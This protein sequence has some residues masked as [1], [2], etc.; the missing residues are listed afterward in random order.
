MIEAV[1]PARARTAPPDHLVLRGVLI[2]AVMLDHNDIVRNVHTVNAWFLPMTWHVAGFLLL[3]FLTPPRSLS[4]PMVRDHAVRYLVPFVC[5][6]LAYAAAYQSIILRHPPD[7][8]TLARVAR[9]LLLADPTSLQHATGFI[10]LWFLPALL[11]VVLLAA[12]WNTAPRLR[13]WLLG[14]ALAVHAGAGA[15]PPE[16]RGMVPAGLLIALYILPLGLL[17]RANLATVSRLRGRLWVALLAA[18]VLLATWEWEHG[19]EIEIATLVVPTLE[20][21]SWMLATDLQD[22]AALALL[23]S[24]APLLARLPGLLTLGRYSLLVYLI[25]PLLYKP[26]LAAGLTL[27]TPALLSA[28][29]GM[30]LYWAGASVSVTLVA[31][32]SLAA[33]MALTRWDGL[34]R[35]AI[36]RDLA[37]WRSAWPTRLGTAR[38]RPP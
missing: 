25:H 20:R 27:C 4:W 23:L 30:A 17:L 26:L 8:A 15:V 37:E 38:L 10:V 34:R 24:A 12:A 9:A 13:P 28:P 11:S 21:P 1:A 31:L 2:L 16:A 18:P 14:L 22:L 33:A 19:H 7:L 3:P 29:N 5:A 32:G 6:V 35:M 36:P